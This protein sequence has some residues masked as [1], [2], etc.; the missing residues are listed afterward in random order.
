MLRQRL[1]VEKEKKKAG[2]VKS[3]RHAH[4]L[5]CRDCEIHF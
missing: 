2:R 1:R 5:P 4:I 3:N